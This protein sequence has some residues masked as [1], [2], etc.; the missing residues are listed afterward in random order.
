MSRIFVYTLG[1]FDA[2]FASAC[3]FFICVVPSGWV[4][5]WDKSSKINLLCGKV[6]DLFFANLPRMFLLVDFFVVDVAR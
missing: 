1:H 6:G 2:I 5:F 4:I 3:F